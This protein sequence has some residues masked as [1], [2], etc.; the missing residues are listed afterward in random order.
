MVVTGGADGTVCVVVSV[1]YVVSVPGSFVVVI[2]G[3]SGVVLVMVFDWSE[4]D[5]VESVCDSV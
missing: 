4:V 2:I 3:I 1:V 5:E